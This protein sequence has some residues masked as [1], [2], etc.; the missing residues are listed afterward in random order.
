MPHL[1]TSFG[2]LYYELSGL[3][4][5]PVLVLSNSLGTDHTMWDA[6]VP[7]L[8][9]HFQ[10]LRYDARG[11]GQSSAPPGPYAV[12][13]LGQDVLALLDGLGIEKACFCGLSLGGLTGQWL[14]INA[15]ERL[16]KLVLSS[17]A[18]RIGTPESWNVRLTQVQAEGLAPL[19][20][21]TAGRWFT[22]AFQRAQPSAVAAVLAAFR[23]TAP[24]GY[25][26]ACAAVRDAD[27]HAALPR[28]RAPTLVLAAEDDP[29]TTP[30]DGRALAQG[31]AG[32]E[33][34]LLP[35][36]HLCNVESAAAYNAALLHFLLA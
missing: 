36:A 31:I 17:T 18:A 2:A 34:V 32:A 21:A 7:A 8:A 11:H 24:L 12:A 35:G 33:L 1:P 27:F 19:A 4:A 30:A 9:L 6:Q 13:D 15:P 16:H 5:A 29:V 26:A 20:A 23:A 3:A 25:A 14:A 10:V 22:A 28:L